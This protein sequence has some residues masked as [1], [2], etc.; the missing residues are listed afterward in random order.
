MAD[1]TLLWSGLLDPFEQ[2]R[3]PLESWVS[4]GV[5]WLVAHFRPVFQTLRLPINGLL[6]S[7]QHLLLGTPPTVV[8][9]TLTAVA[10]QLAGRQVGIYAFWAL[11]FIGCVGAWQPAMV[12]LSL[13]LTAVTI[14]LLLGIPLGVLCARSDPFERLL[15]PL[16]DAMQTLPVFVYLVPVVM[17]FGIG[18][19]PGVI[20]TVI[21]ALPPLVRLTNL[22]IRQVP[23]EV[24][25]AALAFGATPQQILWETQIPLAM[26]TILAGVNQTV[27]FALGMSVV[28]SMIAVPGLGLVVLRGLNG[29]NVGT[30]ATGGLGI[31]LLAILL[32]RVTQ[33]VGQADFRRSWYRRGPIGWAWR[34]WQMRRQPELG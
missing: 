10:W 3:I 6:R 9:A 29:L 4:N 32:D 25:E 24:V 16:L 21:Y 23:E 34:Q 1:L 20:A 31:L 15:R 26:A 17:L 7:L 33:R 18:E 28:T 14:C 13:V 30:A 22:G 11:S 12:S 5:Q 2:V 27:L 8:L 19:A